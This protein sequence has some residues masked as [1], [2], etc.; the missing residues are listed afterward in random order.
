M[1]SAFTLKL[2]FHIRKTNVRAQKMDGFAPKT[3]KIIIADLKIEDKA[4]RS[5]CFQKTFLVADTKYGAI[6]RMPFLKISNANM[7]FG[8]GMLMLNTYTANKALF[9]TI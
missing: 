6:L 8:K 4:G 5:R 3:F 2:G 7:I 1:N 9:N